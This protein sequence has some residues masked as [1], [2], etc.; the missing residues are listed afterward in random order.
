MDFNLKGKLKNNFSFILWLVAKLNLNFRFESCFE[1]FD[2]RLKEDFYI[3][4]EL[5]F[6][7]LSIAFES[8]VINKQREI[9][10]FAS[11]LFNKL[12]LKTQKKTMILHFEI[13]QTDNKPYISNQEHY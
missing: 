8:Q 13:K 7:K 4:N 10:L 5:K 12:P 2:K 1:K 6:A 3:K 9:C 11:N